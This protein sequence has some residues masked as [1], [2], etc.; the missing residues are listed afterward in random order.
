MSNSNN[1]FDFLKSYGQEILNEEA[2]FEQ[3]FEKLLSL[4]KEKKDG[5]AEFYDEGGVKKI[6]SMQQDFAQRKIALAQLKSEIPDKF[7]QYQFIREALITTRLDHP[8]IVPVYDLGLNE[9]GHPYFT[10]KM[11]TG[12]SFGEILNK[13]H[14]NDPSYSSKFSLAELLNIFLKVCHATDFA[15]S[16]GILHMDIKPENIHINDYGE[17]ILIDWGL[18]WDFNDENVWDDGLAKGTPGYMAPEQIRSESEKFSPATDVYALGAVLN[19][20]LTLKRPVTSKDSKLQLQDALI[21]KELEF[22]EN[23]NVPPGLK[24]VMLKAMS[25]EQ[26]ERYQ[27]VGELIKEVTDFQNG[28]A[29]QAEEA[30]TLT[31][32]KL[33]FK[34]QRALCVTAAIATVAIGVT[35]V[36]FINQLKENER[37]AIESKDQIQSVVDQL[38]DSE[39]KRYEIAMDTSD[40]VVQLQRSQ[41]LSQ[42]FEAAERSLENLTKLEIDN[43]EFWYE[44]GRLKISRLDFE[45]ALKCFQ[46]TS[47]LGYADFK[48]NQVFLSVAEK[49]T[50]VSKK[51]LLTLSD[52]K[53]LYASMPYVQIRVYLCR[54]LYTDH[55]HELPEIIDFMKSCANESFGSLK[56][57]KIESNQ[58]RLDLDLSDNRN[59]KDLDFIYGA[60]VKNLNLKNSSLTT[61]LR[62]HQCKL[63]SVNF[64]NS[65]ISEILPIDAQKIDAENILTNNFSLIQKN[66]QLLNLKGAKITNL[67]L[68]DQISIK[69]LK[70]N[71]TEVHNLKVRKNLT[72]D[73][74]YLDKSAK[75]NASESIITLQQKS[76]EVI[77]Q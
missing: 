9:N 64:S 57:F 30:S 35:L 34:R 54:I 46:K 44:L 75:K 17:V 56:N 72:I 63:E 58:G 70:L 3:Q 24:A 39:K 11:L 22:P 51:R 15:H 43:Y 29:T 48:Y 40:Y 6:F 38:K 14:K 55:L 42:D 65:S 8:N 21:G 13:L 5:D 76:K 25:T 69:E 47:E 41:Q 73:K 19:S 18:A 60:P 68:R 45:N 1:N 20:I 28:F 16:Q 12:E 66:I 71:R 62:F 23:S 59:M 33:F 52:F 27:S 32:I 53:E 2:F 61:N 4:L 36:L 26:A 10:M 37:L 74:L 31:L 49:F 67:N 77:F 50:E 7:T